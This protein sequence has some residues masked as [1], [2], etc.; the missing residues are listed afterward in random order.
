[1]NCDNNKNNVSKKNHCFR[2]YE[3]SAFSPWRLLHLILLLSRATTPCTTTNQPPFWTPGFICNIL[4][5]FSVCKI[6]WLFYVFWPVKLWS[7]YR[8]SVL[9]FIL[10]D[11]LRV[12]WSWWMF[13]TSFLCLLDEPFYD[14]MLCYWIWFCCFLFISLCHLDLPLTADGLWYVNRNGRTGWSVKTS[15]FFIFYAT[16]ASLFYWLALQNKSHFDTLLWFGCWR[17][18]T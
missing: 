12:D 3:L 11:S 8:S 13:V 4:G 9:F 2:A 7:F 15:I 14:V 16:I 6:K 18:F 17:N 5:V 10:S 1:M